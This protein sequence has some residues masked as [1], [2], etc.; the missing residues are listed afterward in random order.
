[1]ISRLSQTW[2]PVVITSMFSSKSSSASAGV[3][4]K[5]AAEFSPLAMTRSMAWSRTMPGSRSL[6]MVRPGRPKMSPMKRIRMIP[7][8]FRNGL[9]RLMVTREIRQ[10]VRRLPSL[11]E[12]RRA[13]KIVIPR[14]IQFQIHHMLVVHQDVIQIPEID[15]RQF[16]G[17][18]ALYLGIDWLAHPGIDFAA[19]LVNQGIYPWVRVMAAVGA[20]RRKP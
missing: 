3:M 6:T 1:M 19:G 5:P 16:L 14:W 13:Q 2:L 18:N 12:L 4:P 11:R 15:V 8:A 17:Q 20:I 9:R 7:P 10:A